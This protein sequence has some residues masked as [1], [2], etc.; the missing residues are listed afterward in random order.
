MSSEKWAPCVTLDHDFGGHDV[1]ARSAMQA[2]ESIGVPPPVEPLRALLA[3]E[4][5]FLL[6]EASYDQGAYIGDYSSEEIA[7]AGLAAR[8]VPLFGDDAPQFAPDLAQAALR[9][10]SLIWEPATLALTRI[11]K[12]TP[13]DPRIRSAIFGLATRQDAV[14]P[15]SARGFALRDLGQLLVRIT[16]A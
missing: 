16:G 9:E 12:R 11:L 13:D 7:P 1:I 14:T 3:D 4:R 15:S 8:L 6:P 10:H 2:I 5:V